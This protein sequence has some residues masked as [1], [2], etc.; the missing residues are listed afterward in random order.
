MNFTEILEKIA[1]RSVEAGGRLV[2]GSIRSDII[3][4]ARLAL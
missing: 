2:S 3:L 1:G 4:V